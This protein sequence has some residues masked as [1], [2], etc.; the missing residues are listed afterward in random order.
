MAVIA[1]GQLTHAVLLLYLGMDECTHKWPSRKKLLKEG[2]PKEL[3]DENERCHKIGI[4][5]YGPSPR[6]ARMMLRHA[7]KRGKT[8]S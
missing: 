4:C 7:Q 2:F 6:L 5:I 3:I 1:G 8:T